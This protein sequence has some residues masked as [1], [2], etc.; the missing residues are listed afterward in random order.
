MALYLF[1]RVPME[2]DLLASFWEEIRVYPQLELWQANGVKGL[3]HINANPLP[4]GQYVYCGSRGQARTAYLETVAPIRESWNSR[5]YG[6]MEVINYYQNQISLLGAIHTAKEMLRNTER[7]LQLRL[8]DVPH[9]LMEWL[10]LVIRTRLL[11]TS[12]YVDPQINLF[13]E[14]GWQLIK[15]TNCLIAGCVYPTLFFIY[16]KGV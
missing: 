8:N 4:I 3:A 15:Q 7:I 9:D 6:T 12:G 11:Y 16:R 14:S 2:A 1:Q 10:D 13:V 5:R